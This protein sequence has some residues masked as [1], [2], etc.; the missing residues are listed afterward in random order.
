MGRLWTETK[1]LSQ[2]A[3]RVDEVAAY[4]AK[5][6]YRKRGIALTPVKFG[7]AFTALFLNQVPLCGHHNSIES[8]S[9]AQ[10]GALVHVYTDGSV[11]LAHGGVEMGQGLHVKM[12]QVAARSLGIAPEQ[13]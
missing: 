8:S 11:L 6:K 7:I 12:V 5:N 4:N 3:S 1:Q 10:A 13:V 2:Y 9:N